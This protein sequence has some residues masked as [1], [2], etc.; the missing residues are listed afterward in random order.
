MEFNPAKVKEYRLV[1]YDNRILRNEDFDDDTKDAGEI[2][3]GHNVIAFYEIVPY[4]EGEA[5]E[6]PQLKY[7][8]TET[9]Q[10]WM[11]EWMEVRIRYKKPDSDVSEK[12]AHHYRS[13]R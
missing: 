2:G 10:E 7:Q 13:E 6:L 11:D 1:G 12:I 3:A 5:A 8:T 4:S 9:R